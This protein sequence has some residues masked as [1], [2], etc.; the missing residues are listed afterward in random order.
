MI[1]SEALLLE[2]EYSVHNIGRARVVSHLSWLRERDASSSHGRDFLPRGGG[3]RYIPSLGPVGNTHTH[4]R[5]DEVLLSFLD[6]L[7]RYQ[8]Q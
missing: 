3:N 6:V 2:M 7:H 8:Y 4:P 5:I 1:S